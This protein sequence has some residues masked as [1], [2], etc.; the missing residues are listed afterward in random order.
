MLYL[1]N[2]NS[3]QLVEW[4]DLINSNSNKIVKW[5]ELINSYSI[6]VFGL[7][8][9]IYLNQMV[10]WVDLINSISVKERVLKLIKYDLLLLWP[11][12]TWI[13]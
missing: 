8:Y 11:F 1:T 9:L 4:S 6:I 10:L 12:C 7:S 3:N 13:Q 2:S 5:S